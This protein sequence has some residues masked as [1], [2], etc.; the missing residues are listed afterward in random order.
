MNADKTI[1]LLSKIE[2]F[3]HLD[4]IELECVT[5]YIK[6]LKF[7]TGDIIMR[8]G[9]LQDGG[10]YII[11]K[12]CVGVSVRLPGGVKSKI[13]ELYTNDFFGEVT[14]LEGGVPTAYITAQEETTCFFLDKNYFDALKISYPIIAYKITYSIAMLVCA[15]LRKIN[16]SIGGKLDDIESRQYINDETTSKAISLKTKDIEFLSQLEIFSNLTQHEVEKLMKYM[17]LYSYSKY[18]YIFHEGDKPDNCYVVVQGAIQVILEQDNKISKIAVLGPGNIFGHMSLIDHESRSAAC[19][20]R[21]NAILLQANLDD[22]HYLKD[23]DELLYHKFFYAICH[24]LVSTLR[25]ADKLLI[26]LNV[27]SRH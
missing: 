7:S 3:S 14:L 21:E 8:Q 1:Q 10:F 22:I 12:G 15:R 24:D 11:K 17:H 5:K 13:T 18:T 20:V 2:T 4:S 27:E 6:E 9:Q 26:R 16:S 25:Q 19:Q 23:H